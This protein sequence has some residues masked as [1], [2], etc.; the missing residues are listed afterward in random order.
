MSDWGYY[1]SVTRFAEDDTSGGSNYKAQVLAHASTNTKGSWVQLAASTPFDSDLLMLQYQC[2]GNTASALMDI[3]IGGAGSE[4]VLVPNLVIESQAVYIYCLGYN[5]PVS[6][7]AGTRVA[8]RIQAT[9]GSSDFY[10]KAQFAATNGAIPAQTATDYGA[11]TGTSRGTIVQCAVTANS[12]GSWYQIIASCK[13]MR[14]AVVQLQCDANNGDQDFHFRLGVGG[15]GVEQIVIP[16]VYG[17]A[18][19]PTIAGIQPTSLVVPLRLA[20]GT[21]IAGQARSSAGGLNIDTTVLGL[22]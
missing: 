7:K 16:D 21:R 9:I 22:M 13:E 12:Y 3:G 4:V 2:S 1:P 5:I 15:A 6:I 19:D 14:F 18:G 11:D 8:V 17:L 20:A 10:I